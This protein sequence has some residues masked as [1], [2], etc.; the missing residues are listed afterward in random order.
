MNT[1]FN[2]QDK[3]NE[4]EWSKLQHGEEG[5]TYGKNYTFGKGGHGY[6]GGPGWSIHVYNEDMSDV[7][8][9]LPTVISQFIDWAEENGKKEIKKDF[10]RLLGVEE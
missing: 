6:A 8:W 7:V 5:P 4:F 10:K 2:R 1:V 9:E 3:F